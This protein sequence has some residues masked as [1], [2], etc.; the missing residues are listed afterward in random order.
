MSEKT[1]DTILKIKK[2]LR[3]SMNGVVSTLQRKQGLE[4]KL[5]FGVEIPRIKEIAEQC[6]KSKELASALWQENIRECKIIATLVMP[7][8][9]FTVEDATSWT[10][11]A[12]YTD[13]MDL[14]AM[15]LLCK[16][17]QATTLAL[18][19]IEQD[20]FGFA[21][22]G[23]MTLSNIFRNKGK[24]SNEEEQQFLAATESVL[25]DNKKNTVLRMCAHRS[26]TQYAGTLS[27]DD[28]KRI[29]SRPA[30]I[31]FSI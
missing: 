8:E 21:Y 22:T 6:E 5:N 27:H 14:I 7:T 13:I 29:S 24:L 30:L 17:P 11:T 20:N 28:R 1:S 10:S 2:A 3:L 15:N 23:F 25:H 31:S 26:V 18:S 4:Y 16:M 9:E 12:P 19:W